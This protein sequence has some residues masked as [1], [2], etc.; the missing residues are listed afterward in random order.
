[1]K[2]TQKYSYCTLFK[3]TELAFWVIERT[4]SIYI[5]HKVKQTKPTDD[6]YTISDNFPDK[7]RAFT[8]FAKRIEIRI[9]KFRYE[10][11]HLNLVLICC[12]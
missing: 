8:T 7:T 12:T 4:T 3:Y 10:E 1:M 2:Y 5:F 9:Q 6:S 11:I